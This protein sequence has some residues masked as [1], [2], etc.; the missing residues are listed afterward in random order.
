MTQ[1]IKETI[2]NA[3]TARQWD[4]TFRIV[5]NLSMEKDA[6]EKKLFF[7][8]TNP[9]LKDPPIVLF[10]NRAQDINRQEMAWLEAKNKA[11]WLEAKKNLTHQQQERYNRRFSSEE[12]HGKRNIHG[13]PHIWKDNTYS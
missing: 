6:N 7:K 11:A 4:A 2:V 9:S 13:T 10:G 8:S 12:E 1:E 5:L 3:L